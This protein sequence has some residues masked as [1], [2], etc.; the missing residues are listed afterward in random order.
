MQAKMQYLTFGFARQYSFDVLN[1]GA[2]THDVE[3]F[4]PNTNQLI[5]KIIILVCVYV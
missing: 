1:Y 4:T 3:Q 2:F 5:N